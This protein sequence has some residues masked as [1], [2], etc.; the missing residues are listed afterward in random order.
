MVPVKKK[1]GYGGAG[2]LA[3]YQVLITSGSLDFSSNPAFLD[4]VAT[5]PM[6]TTAGRV[7]H[8]TG[9]TSCTGTLSFDVTD[10]IMPLFSP[11]GGLLDRFNTFTAGINDGENNSAM[12]DCKVTSL[13]ISGSAG[14]LIAASVSFIGLQIISGSG[15]PTNF[16][17]DTTPP[18]GYWY[19]G[20]T[21]SGIKDWELSMT[22]DATPVYRNESSSSPGYIRVG[23]VSYSLS[24]TSY[25]PLTPMG[26]TAG[27]SIS[28]RSF[29]LVGQTMSSGFSFG[30]ITDFGTYRYTFETSS[31]TNRSDGVVILAS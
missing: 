10:A 13:T 16:I 5:P 24:V 18:M 7:K 11:Y 8:A 14:G 30:G 19:S 17:R 22:Q 6:S 15:V 1:L 9:T 27:I 3:G 31:Q 2:L 23:N 25:L 12:A 29:L 20:N 21:A 4:M 28:T 26:S